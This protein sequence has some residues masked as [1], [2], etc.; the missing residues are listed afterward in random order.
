MNIANV[1]LKSKDTEFTFP[2]FEDKFKVTLR[3]NTSEKLAELRKECVKTS[4]DPV[5]G[6]PVEKL[7]ANKWNSLFSRHTIVGWS[8]LTW[9]MLASLML[10]DESKVDLDEVIEYTPDNASAILSGSTMFD[11]WVSGCLKDISNFR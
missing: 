4:I 10:I 6:A 8:G 1:V 9:G 7:D 11:T 5:M 3:Y 2:D